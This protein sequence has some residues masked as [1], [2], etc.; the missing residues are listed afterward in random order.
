MLGR[1]GCRTGRGPASPVRAKCR[2]L[3]SRADEERR[4]SLARSQAR[5]SPHI[6]SVRWDHRCLAQLGA[7]GPRCCCV[8]RT[9]RR[10]CKQAERGCTVLCCTSVCLRLTTVP[11]LPNLSLRDKSRGANVNSCSCRGG[12]RYGKSRAQVDKI[13]EEELSLSLSQRS[14]NTQVVFALLCIHTHTQTK[15][16][17]GVAHYKLARSAEELEGSQGRPGR[18]KERRVGRASERARSREE[19]G[20]QAIKGRASTQLQSQSVN[21]A[22]S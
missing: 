19:E 1:P 21:T 5:Q 9:V 16:R 4:R 17:T 22:D 14:L 8:L 20:S 2:I 3:A 11:L 7:G 13:E 12:V 6:S 18:G 10:I 15:R